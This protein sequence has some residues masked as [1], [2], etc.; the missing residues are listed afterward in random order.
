VRLRQVAL[1]AEQL[2]AACAALCDVLGIEIA[3]RDLGVAVFG[4]ENA[5]MPLGDGFLEVVSPVR[6]DAPARRYRERRGGDAGYMVMLQT[7]R[8]DADRARFDAAG[9]RVVWEGTLP[10]IRGMHLHPKDTGGALLSVDEPVPAHSWRWAGPG[11]RE[12]VRSERV[13]AL[14][15]ATIGCVDP[16]RVA[17]RWSE[18]LAQDVTPGRCPTIALDGS[19]LEFVPASGLEAQGLVGFTVATADREAIL[20]A[21]HQRALGRGPSHVVLCGTHVELDGEPPTPERPR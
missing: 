4:L 3:Y 18:L 16:Q 7:D 2:D 15:G 21:A 12:H 14:R 9:V 6:Q 17:F 10:D 13:T 5:V 11:W 8:F 20:D 19:F 1:V